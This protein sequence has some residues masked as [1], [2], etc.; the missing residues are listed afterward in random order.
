[1]EKELFKIIKDV[2]EGMLKS[3]GAG[4]QRAMVVIAALNENKNIP[5]DRLTKFK[6]EWVSRT[7]D[8]A[9]CP[10]I[11]MEFYKNNN[12]ADAHD[13]HG[14]VVIDDDVHVYPE[15]PDLDGPEV[16]LCDLK[17]EEANYLY[18][19]KLGVTCAACLVRMEI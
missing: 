3:P 15:R 1:M 14:K 10:E 4:A 16:T 17:L 13:G 8:D 2:T 12:T 18:T 7:K 19:E 9:L 11:K 6:V 5:W